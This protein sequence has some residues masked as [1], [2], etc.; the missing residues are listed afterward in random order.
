MNL[1]VSNY[2]K[3]LRFED[4]EAQQAQTTGTVIKYLKEQWLDK[5]VRSV[6]MWLRDVGKGWF[7]LE[8]KNPRVYD[9]MKLKR[10]VDLKILLMQ[11]CPHRINCMNINS[12]HIIFVLKKF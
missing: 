7:N 11:V 3:A 5:I 12:K 4:F 8:Q 1:F 9:V 6:R 2:G 10:F